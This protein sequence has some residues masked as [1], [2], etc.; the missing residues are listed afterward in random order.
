MIKKSVL[1]VV[2]LLVATNVWAV[3]PLGVSATKHNLSSGSPFTGYQSGNEDEVCIFCHTP[4]GGTLDGP[5]WNRT[6]TSD[7]TGFTHYTSSTL[8]SYFTG[9][10]NRAVNPESL[11]CLSCHDGTV[12]MGTLINNSN[13]TAGGAPDNVAMFDPTFGFGISPVIGGATGKDLSNDHPI[14]FSYYS[15]QLVNNALI[16]ADSGPSDPRTKGVRFFGPDAAGEQRVECSSCHD[17]HVN[18]NVDSNYLPFLVM[19]NTGSALC[20]ACHIK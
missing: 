20:L 15:A 5:L 10:E 14:S 11:L 12:A 1:V 6:L 9:K 18:G 17:P 19:S 3:K 16:A 4:H 2:L 8:S 7:G 13:R